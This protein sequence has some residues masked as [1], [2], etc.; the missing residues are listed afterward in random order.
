MQPDHVIPYVFERPI[1]TERLTLRLMTDADVDDVYSYQSRE[2]V[3]RYLLFDPRTREDVA[4]RVARHAVATTLEKD[5]DYLQLAIELPGTA[6]APARVIG[7]LYFTIASVENSRG[8]IGWTVH[9]DFARQGFASEAANALLEVVFRAIR[10]HR[11]I[12]ELDP[13]NDASIAL[14]KRLGMREEAFFVKDLLFKGDWGDTGMYAILREEW[15]AAHWSA[16]RPR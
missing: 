16:A 4:E 3:C 2:D 11:V 5:G 12:A 1:H 13:R 7:D 10:L 9:P 8:E 15:D 14:C 6:S